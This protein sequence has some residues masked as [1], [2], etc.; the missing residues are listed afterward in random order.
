MNS[1]EICFKNNLLLYRTNYQ[2]Q[3]T[4]NNIDIFQFT[5]KNDKTYLS[6]YYKNS[7]WLILGT[8]LIKCPMKK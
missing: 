4:T 3:P 1:E 5:V 8:T 2:I 7:K 6:V